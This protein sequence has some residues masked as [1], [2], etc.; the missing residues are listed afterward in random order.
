MAISVRCWNRWVSIVF[1][2]AATPASLIAQR[3]TFVSQPAGKD[4]TSASGVTNSV[5]LTTDDVIAKMI[6]RNRLRSEALHRYS[7][8]RT[9]EIKNSD[10]KLTA[11]AVVRVTYDAPDRKTF[12]KTS[13]HGSGIVRRLVFD[14]LMQSERETSAG[15]EHHDSAITTGN[16]TFALIGEEDLGQYHC[17]VLQATPKRH[18]KYLFEGRIWIDTR[19]FAIVQIAGHPAKKPSFWVNRAD[20]V[21]QYQ[22]IDEFWL[23]YRDETS[24]E[25]KMYG[26]KT[27]TVDHQQYSINSANLARR[28]AGGT[29]SPD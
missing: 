28:E 2:L 23:P 8:L 13:E 25:V 22:K 15:H 14:H 3:Q 16:Y 12:D 24:V 5:R 17:F 10:G 18:D 29:G 27:F 4:E 9:Y 7:V 21:R 6:E 20:F 11:Q 1:V 26:R 19:D